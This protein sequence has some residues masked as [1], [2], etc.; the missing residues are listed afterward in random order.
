MPA[1]RNGG[2]VLVRNG[3]AVSARNRLLY[4]LIFLAMFMS[5]GHHIDHIIRGNHVGWPLTSEVNAF[6][7][8][9]GIYPLILLGLY[10]YAS[11]RVG[12]GFW[13]LLSGTGALFVAAIHFGPAA[14]E[15]PT[16]IINLYEP[17]I[18]GWMA[19]LWLVVFVGVLVGT[20]FYEL[21]S[22]FAQ[23]NKARS[24]HHLRPQPPPHA[25]DRRGARSERTPPEEPAWEE[26][27]T[28]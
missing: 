2:G 8:S 26:D 1:A 24:L 23:R 22:W 4:A 17:P 10:L 5:L 12:P 28:S 13:A 7:F 3:R 15:P 20:C 14:V 21:R 9:L 11:G 6:T 16:D 18:V 25:E 19:F 27:Q